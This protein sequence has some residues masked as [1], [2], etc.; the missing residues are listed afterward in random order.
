MQV[1]Q[2]LKQPVCDDFD[3]VDD[4]C[5]LLILYLDK[6]V[7]FTL[8]LSEPFFHTFKF[9]TVALRYL[10]QVLLELSVQ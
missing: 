3:L 8:D 4:S 2:I 1:L 5:L 10:R 7:K 9:L 6:I